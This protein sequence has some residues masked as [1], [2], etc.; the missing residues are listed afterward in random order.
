MLKTISIQMRSIVLLCSFLA[1]MGCNKDSN[2]P[3]EAVKNSAPTT[4]TVPLRLWIVGQVSD[5]SLVERAWLTG[6]DQKLEIRTL[7][8]EDFLLEKSCN[9]DVTVFPSRLLGEL[10]DRKWLTK[11]P[12]SLNTPDE[13]APPV[14]AAWTRQATYGGDAWAIPLGASVPVTIVSSSAA[15][16]AS[17]AMDWESLLKSLD[18]EKSKA[19]TQKIDA[20]V[21]NR[22]AL[23]DRFLAIAGGLA[24]RSPDYGLL[25]D[26]Q[27]MKPRLTEPE[28]ARAAEILLMMS[29]QASDSQSAIQSVASDSSQAWTWINAQAKPA[30]TIVVPTLL[31]NEAMK[32]TGCK[33]IRV[34]SQSLGWNTGS[35]LIASLSANCRQSSRATELLQWLRQ[36]ETRQSL[37]ALVTG[38]EA[39]SPAADSDTS[40]WQARSIATEQAAN[41]KIPSELRLPRA[42]DY[43]SVLADSL[44]AIL[45]GE[46]PIADALPEASAAWQKITDARGRE[47]QRHDYEQSLGLTRN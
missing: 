36:S 11:L 21:V 14:P 27:K 9:C 13:N 28:F 40:A 43:R 25:F 12:T 32:L 3:A 33:P 2:S 35:G 42:E 45:S 47:L 18:F 10:I 24:E 15:E 16:S 20:S 30:I 23:V 6:S 44:I 39:V 41:V 8:V 29:Q 22:A 1:F 5:S 17:K 38:I 34:P 7:T 19:P 31:H 46:K 37:S 4:S 26:L